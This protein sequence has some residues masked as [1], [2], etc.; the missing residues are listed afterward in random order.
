MVNS[1]VQAAKLMRLHAVI[2]ENWAF[3]CTKVSQMTFL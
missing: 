2:I 1:H 3:H